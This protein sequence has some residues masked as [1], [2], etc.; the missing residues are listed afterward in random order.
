ML[1]LGCAEI[2]LALTGMAGMPALAFIGPA[3]LLVQAVA[4]RAYDQT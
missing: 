3:L 4:L 2:S 1:M